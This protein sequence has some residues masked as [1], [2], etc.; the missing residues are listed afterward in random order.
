MIVSTGI[1]HTDS[2]KY[3]DETVTTKHLITSVYVGI[4]LAVKPIYDTKVVNDYDKVTGL[5]F[6]EK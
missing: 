3:E 5:I 6:Y 4:D 1:L 2:F